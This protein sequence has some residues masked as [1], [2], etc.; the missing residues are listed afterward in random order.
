MSRSDTSTQTK[1]LVDQIRKQ[2]KV[3]LT[4]PIKTTWQSAHKATYFHAI[5][6]CL[7]NFENAGVIRDSRV[8]Y[9]KVVEP[10]NGCQEQDIPD[11][12][13]PG[14]LI[15]NENGTCDGMVISVS[16]RGRGVVLSAPADSNGSIVTGITIQPIE[17]VNYI[18]ITMKIDK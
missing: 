5:A 13:V 17:P 12:A 11:D 15:V 6:N 14:D 9:V 8:E 10:N 16:E 7:K 2:I 4:P 3:A 1:H 18:M